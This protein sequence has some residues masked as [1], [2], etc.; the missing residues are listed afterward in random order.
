METGKKGPDRNPSHSLSCTKQKIFFSFF[1]SNK[2]EISERRY[3]DDTLFDGVVSVWSKFLLTVVKP[4]NP[5]TTGPH[6]K[7]INIAISF[8]YGKREISSEKTMAVCIEMYE[9]DKKKKKEKEE[10]I[11]YI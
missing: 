9:N 10:A 2:I 11:I 5:W 3:E 6:I 8:Y 7:Q 1:A 4:R